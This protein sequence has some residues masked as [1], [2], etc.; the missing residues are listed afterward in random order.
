M[1][2]QTHSFLPSGFRSV[3]TSSRSTPPPPPPPPAPLCFFLSGPGPRRCQATAV[4]AGSRLQAS[5][6]EGRGMPAASQGKIGTSKAVVACPSDLSPHRS[7]ATP[8]E[9]GRAESAE[10]T[11][12]SGVEGLGAG[13]S[14]SRSP[15]QDWYLQSQ[16]LCHLATGRSWEGH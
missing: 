3:G 7:V 6:A 16:C 12:K 4:P 10:K 1:C 15:Q 5:C 11:G 2:G 8:R 14:C 13:G 9:S